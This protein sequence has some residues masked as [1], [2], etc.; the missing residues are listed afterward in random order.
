VEDPLRHN[1]ISVKFS[2]ETYEFRERPWHLYFHYIL[3]KKKK[4][5]VPEVA[6]DPEN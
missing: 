2:Y 4:K 6:T 5:N 3:K 1:L